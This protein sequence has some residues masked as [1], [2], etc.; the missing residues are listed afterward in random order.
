MSKFNSVVAYF[1]SPDRNDC[2][3][4]FTNQQICN[5]MNVP[6]PAGL[7]PDDNDIQQIIFPDWFDGDFGTDFSLFFD[8][9]ATANKIYPQKTF[10]SMKQAE[11]Y[12]NGL[13]E[14]TSFFAGNGEFACDYSR[15]YVLDRNKVFNNKKSLPRVN[16][17]LN[18]VKTYIDFLDR[19]CNVELW[20]SPLL[21]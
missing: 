13:E 4:Q 10:A 16:R 1:V 12:V 15:C 19:N 7:D 11:I 3:E 6:V 14:A 9:V 21:P 17:I 18:S 5:A 20:D 2:V 8:F